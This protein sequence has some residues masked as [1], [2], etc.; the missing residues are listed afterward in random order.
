VERLRHLHHRLKNAAGQLGL[1]KLDRTLGAL[2]E[3]MERGEHEK[4]RDLEVSA[5]RLIAAARQFTGA[6]RFSTSSR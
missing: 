3:A 4:A 5:L 1:W 2:R 6:N